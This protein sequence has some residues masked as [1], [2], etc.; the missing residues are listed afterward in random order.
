MTLQDI[1][2]PSCPDKS[3]N[4]TTQAPSPSVQDGNLATSGALRR[5]GSRKEVAERRRNAILQEHRRL[6]AIFDEDYWP[7][8]QAAMLAD[9]ERKRTLG[10]RA[11]FRK[12]I[13]K[14]VPV[15]AVVTQRHRAAT[16]VQRSMLIQSLGQQH[17]DEWHL[18]EK[19]FAQSLHEHYTDFN[20][21]CEMPVKKALRTWIA[22]AGLETTGPLDAIIDRAV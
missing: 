16:A 18:E 1:P 6:K 15:R 21:L 14:P 2:N 13:K 7:K 22:E 20:D 12:V 19:E 11:E 4:K 3:I 8:K 9:F 17:A 5:I 10:L